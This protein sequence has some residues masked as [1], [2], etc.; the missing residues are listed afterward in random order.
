MAAQTTTRAAARG[1]LLCRTLLLFF[2]YHLHAP[3][4]SVGASD[5][6]ATRG[7]G[8]VVVGVVGVVGAGGGGGPLLPPAG[9]V[10]ELAFP[11]GA[12]LGLLLDAQ[13]RVVGFESPREH[14]RRGAALA[15]A[16]D[17][18]HAGVVR[19]RGA[20]D[21]HSAIVAHGHG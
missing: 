12:P 9:E 19:R 17:G 20:R 14:A 21:E 11:R 7:S 13:L 15:R 16:R 10:L 8:G 2:V 6:N 3:G 5:T 1:V 18:A 4:S